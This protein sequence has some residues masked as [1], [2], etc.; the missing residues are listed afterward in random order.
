MMLATQTLGNDL[1]YLRRRVSTFVELTK[2]RL[3]TMILITTSAG[4][5]LASSGSL[6]WV[7]LAET[8]IGTGLSAAGVLALNQYLERDLDAQMVRTCNRPL[9]D[10]RVEPTTALFFGVVLTVGGLAFTALRVNPLSALVISAIVVTYLFIYTPLKKKSPLCTVA[11]AV[12][13]ALPPVIGWVAARGTINIDAWALFAILFL[14]QLPHS[15]S[16]A[17]I[18]RDE[19]AQAGFRLL[20]VVHPDGKST[21]RQIVSNCLALLVVALLPTL[22]GIAGIFYFFAALVLSIGFLAFGIK[23]SI[24]P[25]TV[26]AKRLLYASLIYLPLVFLV[27]ALDKTA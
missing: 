18:Y 21:R 20:P 26:S 8:F 22:I 7:R 5:Y 10:K 13:G 12:P 2:P 17:C 14:W 9:P 25:T 6:D 23:L 11:G 1:T 4:F 3:V 19:Y 24:S 16:I 27:M 15:L